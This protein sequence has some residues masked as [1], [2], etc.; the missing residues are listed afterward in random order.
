MRSNIFIA[1]FTISSLL[2]LSACGLG[3]ESQEPDTEAT[4]SETIYPV[5]ISTVIA[6]DNK[7]I[8]SSVGTLRFRRETSLGFTT[9]G[10]V[11]NVQY[12]EGDRVR[13]GSLIAALDTT[14]VNADIGL[15]RA[16]LDRAKSE[17]DRIERLFRQGWVTKSLLER[18]QANYQAAQARIEQANF[19]SDTAKLYAPSNGIIIQRNIDPGQIISAGSPALIFGQLDSG[20]IMRIPLTS[21]DAAKINVGIPVEVSI[22]SIKEETFSARV[23]EIDGRANEQ[24]GA[25]FAIVELPADSRFKSGQIGTANFIIAND[26]TKIA[27]PSGAISGMR[28][29]E[30]IIYVY[31]EESKTVK[32]RN[33]ILGQLNDTQVEV[34][35]GLSLGEQIIVRGHEKLTNG[36]SVKVV[37][38]GE[39]KTIPAKT[40]PAK[41]SSAQT[42]QKGEP[43][44]K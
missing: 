3:N 16:E 19:A 1:Y 31:D 25:F 35:E 15:A 22:S 32:L 20:Y 21:S 44:K 28:V 17:F 26:E 10:K 37:N 33:I 18:S 29:S 11:S 2:L 30:A 38:R 27:I 41:P 14:T 8:I 39:A 9:S 42:A 24:T 4:K 36:D 12:N 43:A 34:L 6:G 5:E 23:T 40:N 13:R 7:D